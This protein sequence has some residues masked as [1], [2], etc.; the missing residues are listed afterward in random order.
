MN[1]RPRPRSLYGQRCGPIKFHQ[2]EGHSLQEISDDDLYF[3]VDA[4][5]EDH[6]QLLTLMQALFDACNNG[7][8]KAAVIAAGRALIDYTRSYFRAEEEHMER[9][10]YERTD[11]HKFQHKTLVSGLEVVV[12]SIENCGAY[13]MEDE[14]L[15]ILRTWAAEHICDE[16]A[17]FAAFLKDL[18][19]GQE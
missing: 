9:S 1:G 6:R 12:R 7:G 10:N 17:Q 4:L 8:D 2:R 18:A 19:K 5:D 14:V 3:G 13:N 11:R 16:D 15:S